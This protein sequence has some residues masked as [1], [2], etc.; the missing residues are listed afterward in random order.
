L[1]ILSLQVSQQPEELTITDLVSI[2]D[3]VA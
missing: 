2:A 1:E 3:L